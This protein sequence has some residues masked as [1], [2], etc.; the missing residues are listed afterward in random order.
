MR[1]AGEL[2]DDTN[3]A[4]IALKQRVQLAQKSV[5]DQN[6]THANLSTSSKHW[7]HK[8]LRISVI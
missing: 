2:H 6:K 7:L 4:I 1:L 3:Q 8:Q 5:K